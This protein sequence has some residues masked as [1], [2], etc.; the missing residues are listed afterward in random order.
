MFE[1]TQSFGMNGMEYNGIQIKI[2]NILHKELK[3]STNAINL[4]KSLLRITYFDEN[5]D[6]EK[7]K[8]NRITI[9]QEPEKRVYIQVKGQLTDGQVKQIW[10]ELEKD[11]KVFKK[12]EEKKEKLVTKDEIIES[13]IES[14]KLM[15]Y[16]INKNDA[17]TFL[18]NFQEKY[19]R[20]PIDREI[21]SIVKGYIIM[22]NEDY[23]LE[24]TGISIENEH[25]LENKDPSTGRSEIETGSNRSGLVIENSVGRRKCPGCGDIGSIHEVIDKSLVL[26]DYPRIYGKK[27]YCGNCGTYWH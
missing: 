27:K 9:L 12:H 10:R 23:L 11:L 16:S 3:F 21:N 17:R 14:I 26:M 8:N 20:L 22:R 25:K 6:K 1:R 18:E 5:I 19:A 2:E 7:Q 13:I 4:G 15:G 24:K